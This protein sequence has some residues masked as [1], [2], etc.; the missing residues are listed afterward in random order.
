MLGLIV[1]IA[2]VVL[3]SLLLVGMAVSY[4]RT[5]VP[6]IASARAA[7][8]QVAAELH[9]AGAKKIYELG[10]G[11]GGLVF[12][13]AK[14]NPGGSVTGIEISPLP[15]L[16]A[17]VWLLFQPVRQRVN[18][19]WANFI[20]VDLSKADAVAFYLMP[21]ANRRLQ[22]KLLRELRSGALVATIAFSM[23]GWQPTKVLMA[24]N[25]GKTRTYLY[26][27]P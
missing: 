22:P 18:F 5:G 21:G 17:Q 26:R 2:I 20:K 4:I 16:F 23:P 8:A 19:I 9:A 24:P 3:S 13:L 14:E 11:T 15:L 7:Q 1:T 27:I 12:R 10:S 6:T 25:F